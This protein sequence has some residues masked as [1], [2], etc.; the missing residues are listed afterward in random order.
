[1]QDTKRE[2]SPISQCEKLRSLLFL[3]LITKPLVCAA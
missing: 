3:N 2:V 1:M